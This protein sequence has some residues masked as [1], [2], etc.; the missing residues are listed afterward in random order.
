MDTHLTFKEHHNRRMMKARAAHARLRALMNLHGIVPDQVQAVEIACIQTVALT[1]SEHWWDRQEIGTRVDVYLLLYRQARSTLDT[2]PMMPMG[3]LM[4]ESGLTPWPE[5]LHTSQER[6]TP[7]LASV[8]EGSKLKAVYVHL[9]S[10]AQICRV[11]AKK[12]EGGREAETMLWP[13]HHEVPAIKKVML[14]A[15]TTAK[16]EAIRWARDRE[17]YHGVRVCMWWTDG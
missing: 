10:G 1:A 2:L 4:R 7:R 11:I 12:Y 9:S 13:N 17:G 6:F 3:A 15:K 16:R 8:C 5:A 14:S